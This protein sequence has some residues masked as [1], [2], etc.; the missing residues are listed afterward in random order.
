MASISGFQRSRKD[1]GS[2]I[3]DPNIAS[4][5]FSASASLVSP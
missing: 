1:V 5:H 4:F 3:R 2:V